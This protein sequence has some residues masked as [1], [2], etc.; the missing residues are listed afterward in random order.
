MDSQETGDRVHTGAKDQKVRGLSKTCL[1]FILFSFDGLFR[2]CIYS[3][4]KYVNEN[5]K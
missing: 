2:T 1:Y 3:F 5:I 4:F